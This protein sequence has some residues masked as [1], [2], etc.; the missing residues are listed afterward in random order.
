M[1]AIFVLDICENTVAPDQTALI[2]SCS[3]GNSHIN[4]SVLLLIFRLNICENTVD[5][6][7]TV[8]IVICSVSS[9]YIGVPY[10]LQIFKWMPVRTM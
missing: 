4:V 7:Q 6:D 3:V 10:L 8:L 2:T 1:V 5:R 9:R